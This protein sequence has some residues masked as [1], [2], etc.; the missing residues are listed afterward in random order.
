MLILS[1]KS[2]Y[3]LMFF[4]LTLSLY[5]CSIKLNK[6][7]NIKISNVIFEYNSSVIQIYVTEPTLKVNKIQS[8][9]NIT[10]MLFQY[11]HHQPKYAYI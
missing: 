4:Y 7:T 10:L 3:M 11:F 1:S 6:H 8:Y 9:L 2:D 5:I